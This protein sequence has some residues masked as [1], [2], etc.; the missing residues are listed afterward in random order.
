MDE[1]ASFDF[2]HV[3]KHAQQINCLLVRAKQKQNDEWDGMDAIQ[4]EQNGLL[5]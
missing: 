3:A 4:T 5:L 1:R 2:W